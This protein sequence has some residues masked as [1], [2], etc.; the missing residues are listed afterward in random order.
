MCQ[1]SLLQADIALRDFQPKKA[2]P[3][4]LLAA[5]IDRHHPG[6]QG[7]L[8]SVYLRLDGLTSLRDSESRAAVL[9]HQAR[10]VNPNCGELFAAAAHAFDA[11]RIYPQAARYYRQAIQVLPQLLGARSELGLVQMRLGMEH[12]AT[13]TLEKAFRLDPFH[14]R[15]KNTLDVLDLLRAMP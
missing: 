12:E 1:R 15:V 8:L 6:A 13:E 5:E 10:E 4:L 7:R 2:L 3:S 9:L 14:L 11:L